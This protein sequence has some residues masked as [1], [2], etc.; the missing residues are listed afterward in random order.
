MPARAAAAAV[1]ARKIATLPPHERVLLSGVPDS[2]STARPRAETVQELE[3]VFYENVWH[4]LTLRVHKFTCFL[5]FSFVGLMHL[6]PS[7]RRLWQFSA[8]HL[9]Q[10]F[11]SIP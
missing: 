4:L 5:M 2:I 1:V 8:D 6:E 9:K 3:E 10:I 7:I 11:C